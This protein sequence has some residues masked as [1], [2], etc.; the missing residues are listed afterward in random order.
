MRRKKWWILFVTTSAT[1]VVF[2]D[3]T[4]MPVALPS[5]QKQL[6]FSPLALI[7]VVNSYL[8]T[9][10]VFLLIGGRLSDLYG[11]RRIMVW[12]LTIFGLGS[13]WSGL[14]FSQAGILAGRVLQGLGGAL[15]VPTTTALLISTFPEGERAKAIGIN[16]GISS[17]FM[18]LGPAVGGFLTQYISWRSIFFLNIPLVIFGVI[19][20][21][22]IVP[23]N[24]RKEETFHFTG[25]GMLVLAVSSLVVGLMQSN[26]WGWLSLKTLALIGASPLLFFLFAWISTHTRHPLVDL[27]IFKIKLFT[28]ANVFIFLSQV[29]VM[30]TVLWAV[31]FQDY[32]GFSPV[33]AGLVIFIAVF[34]VFM[35]APLG[36]FLA[37]KYGPRNP[38]LAGFAILAFGLVWFIFNP[39]TESIAWM[40]PGLLSFGCGIP[41]IMSPTVALALSQ[42]SGHQLGSASGIT[43]ATRQL[44]STTGMALMSTIFFSTARASGSQV[45]AFSAV[46]FAAALF[47]LI[48]F[49]TVLF[50]VRTKPQGV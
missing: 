37:D 12:G 26:E 45:V 38:L 42:V 18:I 28:A 39:G 33:R 8:L 22:L 21:F 13:L 29:I 7:W 47:A 17:I 3:N 49:L 2:L 41:L 31:Y 36:G 34:P 14:S 11:R 5:I 16:T 25:A 32:L 23:P 4:V 24:K 20:T 46:S 15:T 9:L 40:L 50:T 35:M 1:S 43:T 27:K 30:V 19:M 6:N 48:G 44:A 10:T